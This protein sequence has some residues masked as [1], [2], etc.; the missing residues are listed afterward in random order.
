MCSYLQACTHY[1]LPTPTLCL[2]NQSKDLTCYPRI[3]GGLN[4]QSAFLL[5]YYLLLYY[6]QVSLFN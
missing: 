5:L 2:C 6:I 3:F 4:S 1:L